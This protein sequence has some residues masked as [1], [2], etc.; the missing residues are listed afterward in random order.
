[1]DTG[2]HTAADVRCG[3]DQ[4][5]RKRERA[6]SLPAIDTVTQY[7]AIKPTKPKRNVARNDITNAPDVPRATPP[8]VAF[9]RAAHGRSDVATVATVG[10]G[11][12]ASTAF[13]VHT[14]VYDGRGTAAIGTAWYPGGPATRLGVVSH[15]YP[16]P[17]SPARKWG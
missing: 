16:G 13:M 1:M 9:R 5:Q 17:Q 11:S 7:T 10:T 2:Q 12:P 3:G 6:A 15:T 4:R 8:T 14:S